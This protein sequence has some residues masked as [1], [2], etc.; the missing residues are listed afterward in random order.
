MSSIKFNLNSNNVKG[1]QSYKSDQKVSSILKI[2]TFMEL[3]RILF[4]QETHS[5][6]E[7]EVRWSDNFNGQI[8][9][10]DGKS[11]LCSV[12]IDFFGSITY[13]VTKKASDKHGQILIIE[14][15]IDDTEFILISWY[16]A[17]TENDQLT[18]FSELTNTLENFS[19]TKSK[20][21]IF[22]GDFN[23]FLDRSLEA[24]GGNP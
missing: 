16:N 5:T 17:N 15:L 19:L 13:T 12:V 2:T 24:K 10:S 4:F 11:N 1:L 22:A 20:P 7:N 3:F 8:Y 14:A 23:L 9:H 21:I 18:T 6:K